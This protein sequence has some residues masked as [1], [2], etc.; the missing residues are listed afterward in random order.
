ML[1]YLKSKIKTVDEIKL[2]RETLNSPKKRLVM[3]NGCFDILHR[4]H[5]EYLI[6]SREKGD[7]L[8]VALNS[9]DSI[10]QLKGPKRPINKQDDR[11]TLLATF[12]FVDVVTIFNSLR[13]YSLINEIKPEFYVKGGVYNINLLNS[14]E[15]NALL[16]CNAKIEFINLINR[17][18]TSSIL[19]KEKM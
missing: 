7:L 9:D 15:K 16:R 19:S 2:W 1:K 10:R 18:S 4:G 8:V 6:K 3:T 14:S 13:C 11:A 5:I 17:Y 12:F